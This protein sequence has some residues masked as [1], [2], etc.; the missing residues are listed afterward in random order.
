MGCRVWLVI[1]VCASGCYRGAEAAHDVNDAWRG[2]TRAELETRW[3]KPAAV[4]GAQLHWRHSR[5][6]VELPSG[7]AQLSVETTGD[8]TSI[9]VGGEL[10]A[11]Q[12]W[13]STTE[14]IALIDATGRIA[15]VQGP[16]LRWGAPRDANLRWGALF[17]VHAGLG[18][19]DDTSTPLPSGGAY[20]GGML[21]PRHGLVGSFALVSGMDDAGGALGM[22]WGM[23]LQWWPAT[24]VWLRGGPAMILAFDPGFVDVGLE[25]GVTGGASFAVVRAGAFVLDL[26]LDL[27]AGTSTSFGSA[28][29]GVNLN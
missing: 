4:T 20:I 26:R 27:T 22:A 10:R 23:G 21:G 29:I 3:G 19:L 13:T 15:S 6:H 16:S 7:S 9:D 17:G 2:R 1:A 11:G 8:T 25:P 24:R 28:G 12:T 18:R 5:R 14:V